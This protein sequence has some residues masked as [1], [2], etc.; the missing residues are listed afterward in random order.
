MYNHQNIRLVE[1]LYMRDEYRE[2]DKSLF[3]IKKNDPEIGVHALF[4]VEKDWGR[5]VLMKYKKARTQARMHV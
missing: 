3:I 1:E 4:N 2:G 5:S